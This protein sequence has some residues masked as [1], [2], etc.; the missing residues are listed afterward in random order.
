MQNTRIIITMFICSLLFTGCKGCSSLVKDDDVEPLTKKYQ[1]GDYVLLQDIT[2]ND[3]TLAKGTVVKLTF[4]A[5]DEWVKIYAYDKKEELLTSKRELLIYM[6]Q[7]DF[8]D[9][10]FKV[11]L[12]DAE[13]A[14]VARP[15]DSAES[16]KSDTKKNKKTK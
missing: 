7:D 2:R 5:G 4:V 16:G 15:V 8:P 3:V 11:E 10:K 14:R 1:A 12:L 13:L 9:E 6:F